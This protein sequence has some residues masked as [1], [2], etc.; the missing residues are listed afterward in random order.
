[1]I[2]ENA[3]GSCRGAAVYPAAHQDMGIEMCP[4]SDFQTKTI[5]EG[6]EYPPALFL[7]KFSQVKQRHKLTNHRHDGRL[8]PSQ[9][10][11]QTYRKESCDE[12][13]NTNHYQQES[14]G[15]QPKQEGLKGIS[16]LRKDELVQRMLEE[17]AKEQEKQIEDKKA[18]FGQLDSGI[19]A[20]GILEVL[21]DG[22]GFTAVIIIC[23]VENDVYV[24]LHRSAALI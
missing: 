1:M 16:A 15:K 2:K 19:E 3:G 6:E 11:D 8:E 18:E 12:K 21:A 24:I 20:N 23:R 13:K 10:S 9:V 22:Y 4:C 7:G 5:R 17:D 14:F